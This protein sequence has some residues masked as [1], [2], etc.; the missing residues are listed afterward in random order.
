ML[1]N[2]EIKGFEDIFEEVPIKFKED[3]QIEIMKA[4]DISLTTFY[5]KKAGRSVTR[6]IE[7]PIIL[8]IVKKYT[9]KNKAVKLI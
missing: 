1:S 4:L 9:A 3:A 6:K 7:L 8:S 2:T 5:N